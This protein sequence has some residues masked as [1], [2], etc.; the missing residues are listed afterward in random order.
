MGPEM[1]VHRAREEGVGDVYCL[2]KGQRARGRM[3]GVM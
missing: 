1:R 2:I 3:E